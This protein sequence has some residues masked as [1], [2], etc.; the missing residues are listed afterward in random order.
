MVLVNVLN[1]NVNLS[2]EAPSIGGSNFRYNPSGGSWTF[3]GVSGNGSGLVANGSGFSNPNATLG[4]Q[5]AF[6][7]GY[8]SISQLLYGFTPG[9]NYTI[10]Y[11]AA[12]RPAPNQN[13]GESWNV[14]IDGM[15]IKT[16][17]PGPGATTYVN[18]TATFTATAGAHTLGFVGT[19]LAGGDNTVFIDNVRI[20]PFVSQVPPA[21]TL[22]TPANNAVFSAANPV[23][24][25][26]SVVTNGNSIAGV[27][28]YSNTSNLI[29][30]L[31]APYTYAW[32]NAE[33]GASTVFARLVF[34]GS[35]TVDSAI[36]NITVTNPPPI[37]SGIGLGVDGQ[38]LSISGIGL[39]S[40]PYY[41]NA[42][43]NLN[44]PV[45]WMPIQTN[46]AD[47]IGNITF[48]NIASTNTQQFF[49]I[50]AP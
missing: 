15:V 8:G 7:Q 13:G 14:S 44:P 12:Q 46:L 20:S 16:N 28:F 50:F 9:I 37:A 48:T 47:A 1:T 36:V 45:A 19:D 10:T 26:A 43:S 33:A 39:A 25:A 49:R 32:S 5:A 38:T 30:Q 4:A 35:N 34:N 11:S 2:F 29:A 40:R 41:L 22:T 6:V 17:N 18:Y 42:A 31:T 21:V 24:L 23:N 3:S 27:Q